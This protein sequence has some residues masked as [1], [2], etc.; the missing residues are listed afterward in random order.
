MATVGVNTNDEQL[1]PVGAARKDVG[2]E[3]GSALHGHGLLAAQFKQGHF[4]SERP[5]KGLSVAHQPG[6]G[7]RKV[8]AD[9]EQ[10][11]HALVG[12]EMAHRGSVI[13]TNHHATFEGDANGAGTGLEDALLLGHGHYSTV[14]LFEP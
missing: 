12:N 10:F 5:R 1:D 13:C 7:E 4:C 6:G 2:R 9:F 8:V 11:L 14:T 3:G